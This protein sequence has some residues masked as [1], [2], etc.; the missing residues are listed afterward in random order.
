MIF[1]GTV[2]SSYPEIELKY[3]PGM[4][5]FTVNGQLPD[6]FEIL[7]NGDEVFFTVGSRLNGLNSYHHG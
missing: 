7:E 4:L 3:P 2:F 6:D 1:L 5:G